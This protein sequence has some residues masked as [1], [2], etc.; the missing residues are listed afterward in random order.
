M[1]INYQ[2]PDIVLARYRS[3][4]SIIT[5]YNADVIEGLHYLWR[6][7]VAVIFTYWPL[8]PFETDSTSLTTVNDNT[9][10]QSED[11]DVYPVYQ[12]FRPNADA[13]YKVT[14]WATGQ[15]VKIEVSAFDE[16]GIVDSGTIEIGATTAEDSVDLDLTGALD[17]VYFEIKAQ[18]DGGTPGVIERFVIHTKYAEGAPI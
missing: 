3:G 10:E 15:Y 6:R 7:H 13:E 18:K 14:A 12:L 1:A 16:N 9:D 11:L 17:Q 8:A 5:N 2:Y 4:E